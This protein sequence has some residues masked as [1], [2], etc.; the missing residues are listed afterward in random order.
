MCA[1]T[2]GADAWH[3]E[4]PQ[5]S[6]HAV[7]RSPAPASD[8]TT[9]TARGDREAVG[10]LPVSLRN[11]LLPHW[12]D[13]ALLSAEEARY[14]VADERHRFFALNRR[15]EWEA[16]RGPVVG[17]SRW[18]C[19]ERV[20]ASVRSSSVRAGGAGRPGAAQAA[21]SV[22]E[23]MPPEVAESLNRYQ[24]EGTRTEHSLTLEY[25][26]DQGEPVPDIRYTLTVAGD[27]RTGRLNESGRATE[28]YLPAGDAS[29]TYEADHTR[30]P[31]LRDELRT[32]LDS[33]I[34]ERMDRKDRLDDLL[35][36]SD[37]VEQ[38]LILT[39]AVMVSIWDSAR[40]LV[41]STAD[42]ITG[43]ATG[44]TAASSALYEKL[45]DGYS[46]SELEEDF[47]YVAQ[48]AGH[49]WDQAQ[50]AYTVLSWLATDEDTW[51]LLVDFP[52]R[53]FDSMSTV[54]KAE[55]LG[56]L[57]FDILFAIALAVAT[58]LTAGAAA[59]V[60][61]SAAAIKYSR[62]FAETIGTLRRI[63]RVLPTGAIE[64]RYDRVRIGR[65]EQS[66]T[67]QYQTPAAELRRREADRTES[68]STTD[69]GRCTQS[70]AHSTTCGDPINMLTG[71]ELFS[72]VD[73]ELGGPL[74]L[75]WKRLYR[76]TASARRSLLGHGWSHPFDQSLVLRDGQLI[77]CDAEG[78][79]ITY[80]LPASGRRVRNQFGV[81]LSRYE[82]W[83][84][85]Q[86]DGL[87]WHFEPDLGQAERWRLSQL[88]TPDRRHHWQLW[89]ERSDRVDVSEP[90]RLTHATSS[91]GAEVR[92]E[93]GV[94]GWRVIRGKAKP[95]QPERT[96]AHYRVNRDGDL[97]AARDQSGGLEQYRYTRHLFHR[98]RTATGLVFGFEWDGT[99]P[100]ARCTRQFEAS[101]H[102]DYRF[103]WDP[104]KNTS[105]AT[106]GR[107]HVESFVF[108]AAGHL[109][110]R[111]RPDGGREHWEYDSQGRLRA[112]TD[113]AGHITRYDYDHN[114]R[115][116]RRTDALGQTFELHYWQ[117]SDQP[118]QVI[119]P[120]GQRTQYDYTPEGQ[121][122]ACR[123][124]DGTEE[125]WTWHGDRLSHHRD[126]Q[127]RVHRYHWDDTLGTLSRYECLTEADAEPDS[128]VTLTDLRF[129]YDD[130]GRLHRQVDQHGQEQ[131][132]HYDDL[133]RLTTQLN[134]H[135]QAWKFEY[136][137]AGRLIAQTDPGGRTTQLR[138]GAFAQPEARI[139]PNG[140]TI[141]YEY[142]AERNLTAVV[143]GNGQAH[144]FEY[145]GCERL[146]REVGVD[147]RTTDY[148]YNEA[149]H[150]TGLTEGPIRAT[151]ERD[152]LGR[153]IREHY[154]HAD[155]AE[156]V[157][158][159][160]FGYDPLGRLTRARNEHAEHE[161][162]YDSGG[163][164]LED[165][166]R[167]DFP[168]WMNRVR[169]YDHR[170]QFAY[171]SQGRLRGVR[172]SAIIA[173]PPNQKWPSL[174]HD[175]HQPG[176]THSYD[177]YPNDTLKRIGM[178]L[179]DD[180][181]PWNVLDTPVLEQHLNARGQLQQRQQGQHTSQ[182]EY[183]PQN[184]L[185]HYRRLNRH[186]PDRPLQERHYGYDTQGRI[187]HIRDLKHGER[188]YRYDALDQLVETQTRHPGQPTADIETHR[189]DAAGNRLP[190]GL[191]QLLDNR[192]PFHGDRHFDYDD[193][194]N[195][196][197]IRKGKD[198]K[199]E[200]H[201]VYNA[202]HQLIRLDER[203]NGNLTQRLT[204][205]YDAFGRRIDKVV[206]K[207]E[208]TEEGT[209]ALKRQYA[210]AYVW[211]G[212]T[213]VQVRHLDAKYQPKNR[214]VYV[215]E[216]GTH[217]PVALW[218]QALGLMQFDTDHAGTP[219]ALYQHESG[220]LVWSIDHEVY[221]KTK[222]NWA[223]IVHPVTGLA[224]DAGLRLQGQ[225]EDLE[226]GLH[227]NLC[228]YY[229][230]SSGR[231]VT[232]DP[233][234][235]RGGLNVYQYCPNPVLFVDPLGLQAKECV[236]WSNATV[237]S[238]AEAL[239]RG[240][241]SVTVNSRSEAEELFLGL[242]AGQGYR[243]AEAFNS[244][245]AKD[246][247]RT[248]NGK[249]PYYHWDDTPISDIETRKVYMANHSPEDPHAA[250]PHLQLH[251]VA[252]NVTRIYWPG[253]Y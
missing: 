159:T 25:L 218:D 131:H 50:R 29:V 196:V 56:A 70:E 209:E 149:G 164:L 152:P 243:N 101:G 155:R 171:D 133:G 77:H 134:E 231:F 158:W 125:R 191:E 241:T 203:K 15:G 76:S 162:Q 214:R 211:Q 3:P 156:A 144:R 60:A 66:H 170:Q 166:I 182:W 108:D 186:D 248:V 92:F 233:L 105:R 94:H 59:A 44:L 140:Q 54:E 4:S 33:I 118:S 57:A 123:H 238:A 146:T 204:F 229:E 176:W 178:G 10:R 124:P 27:T 130:Q 43:A 119:D 253:N 213:L 16:T 113:G 47:A 245:T 95:H 223:A 192:L 109:T 226:T 31:Q 161:L 8:E 138:Y 220:D 80:P 36:E 97:I 84:S 127:G 242:F 237:K 199:L 21:A 117:D 154:D 215:Y 222:D 78:A 251:P 19:L 148:R 65:R 22:S 234:G 87:V 219:K 244:V 183:D 100:D 121:L 136:D 103:E 224:F 177:W 85:L 9:T 150:L 184:R 139:L 32:L 188:H 37:F 11:R 208:P 55:A 71:E 48:E 75:V 61:G 83:F 34:N 74:P 174:H 142:D 160:E 187:N 104:A 20:D 201:L 207:P 202:K 249:E 145:D 157:T 221:G 82:D 93:P 38:G 2:V 212:H 167:Q 181:D 206:F 236:P 86:Q 12:R 67:G 106:D 68:E 232:Q 42:A 168:G 247:F 225:Y 28:Q 72:Q 1:H 114:D 175:F 129:D 132:Y 14:V 6:D 26:D 49:A 194:G 163:R 252:G 230:P 172:H 102:Y 115:L 18:I 250:S 79:S 111:T 235:I 198:K 128:L 63:Y 210:E 64:K 137:R 173:R 135:G 35:A 52:K 88:S 99:G 5:H 195:L 122:S 98:R 246:Y 151:F 228:R 91:W 24:P 197:R 96:L 90:E 13:W 239:L 200:Q 51:S 143:N 216:P 73:F 110:E 169:P 147:G 179:P 107:G 217:V 7:S 112:H 120:L 81:V 41:S 141:G 53:F 45:A 240:D 165:R 205:R 39:G 153:L 116:V 193:H 17:S 23:E 227:Q 62:Y 185:Q 189:Q 69:N 30:L 58:A 190:D 126:R 40:D 46:L 89:Y 180:R